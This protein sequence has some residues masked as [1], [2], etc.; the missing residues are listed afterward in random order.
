METSDVIVP[1]DDADV[2]ADDGLN[3][4]TN[5]AILLLLDL[6]LTLNH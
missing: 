2:A 1:D 4:V 3:N 6:G 5:P